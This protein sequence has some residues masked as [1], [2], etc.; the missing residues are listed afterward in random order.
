MK[1]STEERD[2]VE[3]N[4]GLV[5][6]HIKRFVSLPRGPRRDREYDDLFQEGSIA[7]MQA[8]KTHDPE[9]H[10][11]F[12]AYAIPRIHHAISIALYE[13]FSTV[14]V[15]AKS[16]KRAKQRKN[17]HTQSDRHR[18]EPALVDTRSMGDSELPNASS[19]QARHR[20]GEIARRAGRPW[21][22]PERTAADVLRELYEAAVREASRRLIQSGR[23]RDDR[24]ELIRRFVEERLLVPEASART[25][26]R[27]LAREFKCS[28]G[29]V[30]NC[31]E[32]LRNEV[33]ELLSS[34]DG[35]QA[36]LKL[37][38]AD[39][40]GLQTV[41]DAATAAQLERE[42][43]DGF[44]KRFGQLG[45]ERQAAVLRELIRVTMGSMTGF[46]RRLFG[47]LDAAGRMKI[48]GAMHTG[49]RA[50]HRRGDR[51]A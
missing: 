39:T 20:P 30:Q 49:E 14:R 9:R 51:T 12:A 48:L 22:A 7:L 29:R 38:R 33:R 34:C 47:Q 40:D 8:A 1:L 32:A 17:E 24:A 13:R 26:K 4:L 6:V 5:N 25:A 50:T 36:L 23:G 21:K 43:L 2:L 42:G 41:L 45:A 31:E 35:F 19:G 16:V 44:A 18:P 46:A 10:G 11:P 3:Q 28:I 27:Q 15:P 37:S